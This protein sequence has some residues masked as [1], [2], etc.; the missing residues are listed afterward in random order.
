MELHKIIFIFLILSILFYK[1]YFYYPVVQTIKRGMRVSWQEVQQERKGR[2][3]RVCKKYK[4]LSLLPISHNRFQYSAD[5]NLMFCVN[6]K[7]GGTSYSLTT[8][9]QILEGED[10]LDQ[11]KGLH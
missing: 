10:W 7:V 5:Y 6:A 1:L 3:E 4:E 2:I 8:F 11:D 9:A